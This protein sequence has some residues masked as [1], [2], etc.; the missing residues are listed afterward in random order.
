MEIGDTNLVQVV[1]AT[2]YWAWEQEPSEDQDAAEDQQIVLDEDVG[3]LIG[4]LSIEDT[5]KALQ[6]ES[7]LAKLDAMTKTAAQRTWDN[8]A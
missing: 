3:W 4:K 8:E 1:D 2:E 6:W 7:R 5:G